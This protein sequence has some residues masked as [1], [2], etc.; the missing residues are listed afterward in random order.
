MALLR[1]CS[2]RRTQSYPA[3]ILATAGL[4]QPRTKKGV[5]PNSF[6]TKSLRHVRRNKKDHGKSIRRH[7]MIFILKTGLMGPV[8]PAA[9]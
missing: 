2:A 5:K 9:L 4:K 1:R 6:E 3:A 7:T 8:R